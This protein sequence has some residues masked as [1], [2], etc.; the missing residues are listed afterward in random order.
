MPNE[1]TFEWTR[2]IP[3]KM[4]FINSSLDLTGSMI[5]P[6]CFRRP[7]THPKTLA[8]AGTGSTSTILPETSWRDHFGRLQT[9][10]SVILTELSVGGF[11]MALLLPHHPC[12]STE[13]S[14]SPNKVQ[15]FAPFLEEIQLDHTDFAPVSEARTCGETDT[16]TP[17]V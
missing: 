9:T 1:F 7:L 5:E 10:R 15:L 14:T 6:C 12:S 3:L 8:I 16:S 4:G 11:G 2:G 13:P 17:S